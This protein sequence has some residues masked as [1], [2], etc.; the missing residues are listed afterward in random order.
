VTAQ[1]EGELRLAAMAI[2]GEK[3][4]ELGDEDERPRRRLG[5]A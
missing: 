4:D 2:A 1:A 5:E 3:A